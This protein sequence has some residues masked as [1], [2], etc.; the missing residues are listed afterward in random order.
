MDEFLR[1]EIVA[2]LIAEFPSFDPAKAV[3]EVGEVGRKAVVPKIAK[4][5]PAYK[6]LDGL[7]QD[8]SFLQLMEEISSIPKLIYDPEYI[9]GGTHENL[10]GQD[11]DV[12]VD[13]NYHP[14]RGV[15][16]RLNLILFL[17]REWRDDWGGRLELHKDPWR[18]EQDCV[19]TIGPL[20]NRAVLFETTEHSWHGFS[21]IA[22]PANHSNLSRKSIAVY[23][24]TAERPAKESVPSHGTVYVPRPLPDYLEP[25][26]TLRDCDV[27]E[28]QLVWKRQNGLLRFLYKRELEFSKALSDIRN[29]PSFRLGRMLTWPA[30]A[31]RGPKSR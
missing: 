29:S 17:N 4:L 26:Y 12:H 16:R 19:S 23:Y 25:G 28:L 7:L 20:A 30:R 10:A 11:L 27:D 15:H 24:Y 22:L 3:N 13:F 14:A 21:R 6:A 8:P 2:E 18:P 31:L 5:G 1:P 9:G